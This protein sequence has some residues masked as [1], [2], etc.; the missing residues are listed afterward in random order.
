MTRSLFII[1]HVLWLVLPTPTHHKTTVTPQCIR[2]I[3]SFTH[4][5]SNNWSRIYVVDLFE[6]F[7]DDLVGVQVLAVGSRFLL[8]LTADLNVC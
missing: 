6:G 5:L 1:G 2:K 3:S 7:I 4:R 8:V